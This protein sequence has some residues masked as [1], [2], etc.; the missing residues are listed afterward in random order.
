MVSNGLLEATKICP[1][2]E[3]PMRIIN[4]HSRVK[5]GLMFR[6]TR[7]KCRDVKASIRDGT[8]YELSHMTFMEI[9]RIIFYYFNRGFN[10]L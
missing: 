3:K 4:C 8:I 6:C 10:A 7:L 9:L 2:C 1:C 5:D